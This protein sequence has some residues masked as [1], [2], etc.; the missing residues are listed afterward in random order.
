MW[1]LE[2]KSPSPVAGVVLPTCTVVRSPK[3]PCSAG[4]SE[5]P[6]ANR[7]SSSR[8]DSWLRHHQQY[9]S[10]P[11]ARPN[12]LLSRLHLHCTLLTTHCTATLHDTT[13]NYPNIFLDS[14]GALRF[15]FGGAA[16]ARSSRGLSAGAPTSRKELRALWRSVGEVIQIP[17]PKVIL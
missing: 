5:G 16:M 2:R 9:R 14:D 7:A 3:T 11:I 17:P 15:C 12:T 4:A 10:A 8:L 1:N 6:R 13:I